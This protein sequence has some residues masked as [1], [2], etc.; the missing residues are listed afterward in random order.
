[1][2]V[3]TEI[4]HPENCMLQGKIRQVLHLLHVKETLSLKIVCTLCNVNQH[5]TP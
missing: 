4:Q 3:L 5:G 2:S 1:M